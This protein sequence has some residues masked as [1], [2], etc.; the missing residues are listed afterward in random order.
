MFFYLSLLHQEELEKLKSNIK[1]VKEGGGEENEEEVG[2]I[3]IYIYIYSIEPLLT[4][5]HGH[6][7]KMLWLPRARYNYHEISVSAQPIRPPETQ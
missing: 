5:T 7:L 3:R 4:D 1:N 2:C 6:K